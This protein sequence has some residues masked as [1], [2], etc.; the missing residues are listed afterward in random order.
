M[1]VEAFKNR[2]EELVAPHVQQLGYL[3]DFGH[4]ATAGGAKYDL[5]A[6]TGRCPMG[7]DD[8]D[9]QGVLSPEAAAEEAC[10][11]L[12]KEFNLTYLGF[13]ACEKGWGSF[14]FGVIS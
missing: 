11:E 7:G 4:L 5:E 9:A 2:A 10:R 3:S 13:E 12:A 8:M 14:R 6:K 1:D